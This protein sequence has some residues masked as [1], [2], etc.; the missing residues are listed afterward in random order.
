MK[1]YQINVKNPCGE[2][3][4][5]MSKTAQGKFCK[6]CSKEVIDFRKLS[7]NEIVDYFKS[8]QNV[9][10]IIQKNQTNRNLILVKETTSINSSYYRYL[11]SGLLFFGAGKY[12]FSQEVQKVPLVPIFQ[13]D[14]IPLNSN[15][16][17]QLIG[18]SKITFPDSV[19]IIQRNSI[20][21]VVSDD[22]EPLFGV[23]VQIE[24]TNIGSSTDF[25]GKYSLKVPKEIPDYFN[26]IFNNM[27]M[28]I[29]T[30]LVHKSELPLKKDVVFENIEMLGIVGGVGLGAK[31]SLKNRIKRIFSFSKEAREERRFRGYLRKE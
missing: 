23:T 24:G 25:D 5:E 6:S 13:Q 1:N 14:T 7:D 9:C 18:N 19:K 31:P 22:V 10:G 15:E 27:G 29:D 4:S 16:D 11:L 28:H 17:L 2:K 12:A 8:H 30:F 21:G 26:L 3:W 20:E